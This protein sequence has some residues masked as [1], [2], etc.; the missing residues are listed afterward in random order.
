MFLPERIS[1]EQALDAG[2]VNWCCAPE[3]LAE[4][5]REIARQL[6]AGPPTAY[7]CM[8]DNLNRAVAVSLDD[9][10]DIEAAHQVRCMMSDDHKEGVTA[11]FEG[12]RPD[13]K[14]TSLNSCPLP[15]VLTISDGGG[16]GPRCRPGQLG[17]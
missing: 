3:E 13:R 4:R 17:L 5:S 16:T 9:Y 6:A 11:F 10:L 15:A 1:V 8:K 7:A 14:S 12:R 2:L